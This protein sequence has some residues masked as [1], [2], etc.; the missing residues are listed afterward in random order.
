MTLSERTRL[1]RELHDGIAQ[2]LVG[3]GYSLDLLL[4][5]PATP[6]ET[7]I[8]LRTLR[9]TITAMIDK[10]RREIYQ[11][12]QPTNLS[13]AKQIRNSTEEICKDLDLQMAIDEIPVSPQDEIAY[14][15]SRIAQELLRNIASH[16]KA[17]S[18]SVSLKY[19]DD[20]VELKICDDGTGGAAVTP[21]H[22]GI[23]GIQERANK[24]GGRLTI[25]SSSAGTEV[26]LQIPIAEFSR[27]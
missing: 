7:R 6:I 18:A 11:L 3:I 13:V 16:S 20:I 27:G 24:I 10:V 12:H 22:Y 5:A 9:F 23:L 25:Q 17:N 4:S 21:D 15:M 8:D 2:D 14:E 1:A 19:R 26:C